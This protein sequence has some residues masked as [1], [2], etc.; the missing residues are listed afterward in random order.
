MPTKKVR[1]TVAICSYNIEKYIQRAIKSVVNQSFKNYEI[2]IVDD[3]STD[4]TVQRAEK[5][6]DEKCKILKT[7]RNSGT[8][9][10]ARN[11][12]IKKAKG[13]YI[14]FLDGDDALYDNEVLERIDSLIENNEYDIIYLGYVSINKRQNNL[15][16]SNKENSTRIA[17]LI[18]DESFSVSSKCWNTE[19]LRKN[20]MTFKEGIYYEDELFSIKGNIL[21]QKT[22]FGEFPIFKYYRNREGSVMTQPTIKKC[23]D[24]YRML[25]EVT[26]LYEITP[27]EDKKYLLSFIKNENNS[28]PL[29]M[30]V[31]LEAIMQS[32]NTQVLPKRA[33]EYKDFFVNE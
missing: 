5:I 2:I 12:A 27:I 18:C 31:V 4:K 20:D 33:Y 29:R 25:A 32:G 15:R 8:A 7:K 6:L 9:A 28:I 14:I 17:R 10:M 16:L 13:E 23:S 1:F 22:T 26:E 30:R 19:F 24:W 21:S 3:C 11:I